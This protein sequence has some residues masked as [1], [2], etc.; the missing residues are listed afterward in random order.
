MFAGLDHFE[1]ALFGFEEL[2][3]IGKLGPAPS[4]RALVL[5]V[6][7]VLEGQFFVA[8]SVREDGVSGVFGPGEFLDLESLGVDKSHV[9]GF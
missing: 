3:L 4:W 6:E 5:H 9:V 2:D 1:V 8:P 7:P